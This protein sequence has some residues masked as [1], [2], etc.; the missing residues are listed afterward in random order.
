MHSV[1]R[2]RLDG[3]YEPNFKNVKVERVI[4]RKIQNTVP[5]R[6]R[7]LPWQ[8]M[9]RGFK[10]VQIIRHADDIVD[11][12]R[13]PAKL[14]EMFWKTGCIKSS[15]K[16]PRSNCCGTLR[17]RYDPYAPDQWNRHGGYYYKCDKC[18]TSNNRRS[19]LYG[20]IFSNQLGLNRMLQ[21]IFSYS[22]VSHQVLNNI[23]TFYCCP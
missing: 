3:R 5:R 8:L 7:P 21:T 13:N 10:D 9:L 22:V 14:T 23:G 20:S 19:I 18:P 2:K 6:K 16:C 4:P 12:K 11:Y 17:I 1:Y 15:H